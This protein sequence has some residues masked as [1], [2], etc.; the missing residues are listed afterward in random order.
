MVIRDLLTGLKK[1][2]RHK[3]SCRLVI[4]PSVFDTLGPG[5][6]CGLDEAI[7]K[8]EKTDLSDYYVLV[9]W[10]ESQKFLEHPEF[11]NAVKSSDGDDLDSAGFIPVKIYERKLLT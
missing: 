5:C 9:K 1:Y 2:G 7:A 10:P 3:D 11:I 6:T 8:V 4:G